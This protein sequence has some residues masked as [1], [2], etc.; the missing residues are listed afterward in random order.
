[1]PPHI[2]PKLFRI[3][4]YTL[5]KTTL[6]LQ[7]LH[8]RK[9]SSGR[10]RRFEYPCDDC[11]KIY[12][13]KIKDEIGK[14]LPWICRSC[15]CKKE[16]QDPHY[17]EA[18][19]AGFTEK[20]REA[21]RECGKRNMH[22][23]W[24]DPVKRAELCAKGKARDPEC[25]AR[26][27]RSSKRSNTKIHWKTGQELV[28][29]G[30]YELAFVNWANANFIDF[31]W[32][33]PHIMENGR[34][35]IIDAFIKTGEFANT[36]IEIKGTWNRQNGHIGREKWEAFHTKYTNSAL[37]MQPD[38][39]NLGILVRGKPNKRWESEIDCEETGGSA[40]SV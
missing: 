35:Y 15:R 29:V 14:Q 9:D 36:W 2:L 24:N 39:E 19:L 30:G 37:W 13:T 18:I 22:K 27:A 20:T 6:T 31:D 26:A 23:M 7:H 11:G 38:L 28:C 3:G 4:E 16:W 21:L 12:V 1:M 17:R 5:D 8:Q 34:K 40:T 10:K 33:I 25:Y 32:Q